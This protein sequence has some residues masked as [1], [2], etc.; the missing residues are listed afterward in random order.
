MAPRG[1][2]GDDIEFEPGGEQN[3]MPTASD[4]SLP[5]Q[6]SPPHRI[7]ALLPHLTLSH[8]ATKVITF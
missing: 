6:C 1:I 4:M 3:R 5:T 2:N 7:L 8:P